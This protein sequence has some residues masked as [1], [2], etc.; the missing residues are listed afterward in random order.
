MTRPPLHRVWLAMGEHFLDTETRHLLPLT[1]LTCVEAGLGVE[2]VRE[3]WVNDVLPVLGGNLLSVA[4]TWDGWDEAWLVSSVERAREARG[5]AGAIRRGLHTRLSPDVAGEALE[6][7]L[8]CVE[9]LGRI[10]GPARPA[11]AQQ[12]S[13]LARLVFDFVPPAASAWPPESRRSARA[14]AEGP[15]LTLLG[16][17]ILPDEREESA[18]RLRAFLRDSA[19]WPSS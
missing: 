14:L 8:L 7:L 18:A 13:L 12:L 19:A 1:S 2:A 17:V 9:D 6:S 4:G 3:T 10:P 5:A 15:V 11:H 16:P